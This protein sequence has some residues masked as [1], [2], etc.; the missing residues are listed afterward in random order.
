MR[1]VPQ[2][3]GLGYSRLA[4]ADEDRTLS[5][6]RGLQTPACLGAST[7]RRSRVF[8]AFAIGWPPQGSTIQGIPAI[9]YAP[10]SRRARLERVSRRSRSGS[11]PAMPL[12][13]C[14]RATSGTANSSSGTPPVFSSRGWNSMLGVSL[15][16]SG[17]RF[18]LRKW[19]SQCRP[20]SR[21]AGG[22]ELRLRADSAC[23]EGASRR[24]GVSAKAAVPL[25]ARN[26]LHRPKP[27]FPADSRV[28]SADA[29]WS[30]GEA[31]GLRL[32]D[33]QAKRIRIAPTTR[34]PFRTRVRARGTSAAR[35]R[36]SPPA[37]PQASR[38]P[39]CR[40][41]GCRDPPSA[42]AG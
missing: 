34:A 6:L 20:R 31:S 32:P 4:G 28:A 22:R 19:G 42:P 24:T 25:R 21:S 27:K 37:T 36:G 39:R 8:D 7:V 2:A 11:R 9:A 41:K 5:R 14:S 12:M 30:G 10:A 33:G 23:T 17:R 15:P 40:P 13:P 16:P 35:R 18:V 26:R 1:S 38:W 3:I 29:L